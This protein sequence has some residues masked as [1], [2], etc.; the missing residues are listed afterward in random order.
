[1]N[2]FLKKTTP[3]GKG[4]YL[5]IYE[6]RYVP[7]KGKRNRCY[8]TVGYVRDLVEKGIEDPVAH[9]QREVDRLNED[10][11]MKK[12]A[13]AGDEIL[14]M[15]LGHFLP[16][17]MFDLLDMDDDINA[18]THNFKTDYDFGG[19][20]RALCCAAIVNPDCGKLERTIR[21]MYGIPDFPAAQISE[22]LG[23]IGQD[24]HKFVEILN[25]HA[26]RRRKR[27]TDKVYFDL[28]CRHL[29]TEAW[30]NLSGKGRGRF[31][32][33]ALMLDADRV[34][35]DME[36]I[37]EDASG[38]V[39]VE[40]IIADM[41]ER[42]RITGKTIRVADAGASCAEYVR[43]AIRAGDGYVF[44]AAENGEELNPGGHGGWT[45]ARDADGTA[46]FSYKTTESI[47]KNDKTHDKDAF[48]YKNGMFF[49]D[50]RG[51]ERAI[52]EKRVFL[53]DPDA[54]KTCPD[55][56]I[57]GSEALRTAGYSVLIAGGTDA[58]P[59]EICRAYRDMRRIGEF[60]DAAGKYARTEPDP[61]SLYGRFLIGYTA[62]SVLKLL[63][64]DVFGGKVAASRL[65]GFVRNYN[66]S[67][68]ATGDVFTNC[69]EDRELCDAVDR[70][71]GTSC[72]CKAFLTREDMN[73]L[74][75]TGIGI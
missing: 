25:F 43:A 5:Q 44:S 63:E 3:S 47:D 29:G 50:E 37:P 55:P 54:E 75:K 16:N 34:P 61:D 73:L 17:A 10:L 42:N 26:E 72:V 15:N 22:A 28:S 18:V 31:V 51:Y 9:Y 19:M 23:L 67:K 57:P 49:N 21:S 71:M 4:L 2:Y 52:G 33:R 24:Y 11:R 48:S 30:S 35:L 53:Y 1:M 14:H 64:T 70:R 62:E 12:A 56:G 13:Q 39:R 32:W 8:R 58:G 41:R 59:E 60:I 6:S 68:N 74:L 38:T 45:E 46:L 69:F 40:D 20:L 7:G 65:A 27:R 36:F 66:V